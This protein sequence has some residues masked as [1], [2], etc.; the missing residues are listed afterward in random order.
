MISDKTGVPEGYRNPPGSIWAL[1]GLSGEREGQLGRPRASFPF[2]PNWPRKG[3][4]V[5][6]SFLPPPLPF[7]L[8]VGVGKKGVLLL[9]GGGG[10]LLG[11]PKG[12]PASPLAPLYTGAGGTS[13]HTS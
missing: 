6:L 1:M 9:L 13:R 4:G 8:L 12:R 5:P 11:A 10:L 7:P 3:G 2:G